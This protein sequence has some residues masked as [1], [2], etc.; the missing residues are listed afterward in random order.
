[1]SYS[2]HIKLKPVAPYDFGL[3]RVYSLMGIPRLVDM[4]MVSFGRL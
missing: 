2:T 4:R 1:M 3:K